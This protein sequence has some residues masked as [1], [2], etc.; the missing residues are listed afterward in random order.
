M[1]RCGS[2]FGAVVAAISIRNT[3]GAIAKAPATITVRSYT[4]A[5]TQP[6]SA[7]TIRH[8]ARTITAAISAVSVRDAAGAIA[9][10]QAAM[11]VRYAVRAITVAP[12]AVFLRPHAVV[13][14]RRCTRK[15][16]SD[17]AYGKWRPVHSNYHGTTGVTCS[18]LSIITG[19]VLSTNLM[20]WI[21]L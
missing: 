14:V 4:R 8:D 5:I 16:G 3:T 21:T 11:A 20:A 1:A 15:Q 6:K 18:V 10:I 17:K 9:V 7:R 19:V 12:A 13:S 2:A